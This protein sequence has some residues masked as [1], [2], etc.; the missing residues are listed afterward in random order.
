MELEC[1]ISVVVDFP[2]D[3]TL[4]VLFDYVSHEPRFK[5]LI[6]TYGHGPV[7]AICYAIAIDQVIH[8]VVVVTMADDDDDSHQIDELARLV[9]RGVVSAPRRGTQPVGKR[10]GWLMIK[11]LRSRTAGTSLWILVR[12]GTKDATNSFN[13]YSTHFLRDA[14]IESGSGFKFGLALN[15]KARRM[16]LPVAEVP[17]IRL[18]RTAGKCSF[19]LRKWI[20]EYLRWYSY[21]FGSR[22]SNADIQRR[23]RTPNNACDRDRPHTLTTS[24]DVP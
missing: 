11:G 22:L 9:E 24:Q 2:K 12:V 7:N 18:G 14:E 15:A 23:S 21:A 17:T 20:P 1:E 5:P 3:T 19:L 4:S 13:G 16:R 8:P 6:S 10:V